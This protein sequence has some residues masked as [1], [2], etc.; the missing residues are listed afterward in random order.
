MQL[1][2]KT[3]LFQTIQI[4]IRSQFS[5]IWSVNKTIWRA[6]TPD[7]SGP[8]SYGN[9]RELR[10]SKSSSITGSLPSVCLVSYPGH[11]LREGYYPS[12]EKQSVYSLASADWISMVNSRENI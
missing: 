5:S 2:I 8:R 7:Q 3:I 4:N 11:S 12:S 1:N 10:F 6:T 9:K